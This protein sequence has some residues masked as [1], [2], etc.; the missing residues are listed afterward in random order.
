MHKKHPY[1]DGNYEPTQTQLHLVACHVEGNIPE[2]LAG[3]QFLR[4]GPNSSHP[5]S[6]P[7]ICALSDRDQLQMGLIICSMEM[8]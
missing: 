4:N 3:G 8:E 2:E 1:L 5:R 7:L 6:F